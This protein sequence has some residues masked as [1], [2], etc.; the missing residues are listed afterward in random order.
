LGTTAGGVVV[1]NGAALELANSVAI[2]AEAATITGMGVSNGGALRNVASNTSSYAGAITIGA[3]GARI[4]S[5]SGGALTLTGGVVT[6]IGSDVTFGGSGGA[7]VSTAAISGAGS[8]IKVGNGSLSL[9]FANTHTGA[10]NVNAGTLNVSGA[11]S[12][13]TTSAINVAAGARFANNSSIALALAPTLGGNGTGSR[14][15][16]GGTGTLNA[17]LTLDNVGD[18]LS[19]GNSPGIMAFGANQSWG[20]Y[21]YDW[22]L[23]DWAAKV[24]GTNIDQINIT[25]GLTLTGATPGSYILNVLS[26]TGGDV[27][28]NVPN[29]ADVNNSWTILTTTGGI[30]GFSADYWTINAA[31]FTSSPTATGSWNVAQSGNDLVLNYVAVPEPATIVLVAS[32]AAIVGCL[33]ARRRR[34]L[35]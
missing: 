25:G 14:A 1:Q 28:G 2:G 17:A 24:A 13:N 20:S 21:S 35:T 34:G 27:T 10:T 16:Y 23:N 11:G 4:T 26:L 18:V 31:G 5:D 8:L 3:G 29:F 32:G 15:V 12:I 22:E 19:P 33:L 9:A 30:S 7:I 6:A